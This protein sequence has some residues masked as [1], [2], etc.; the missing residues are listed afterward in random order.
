MSTP[1]LQKAEKLNTSVGPVAK[2]EPERIKVKT[3]D[4]VVS[5]GIVNP[6]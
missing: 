5:Y 6:F 2:P 3:D 1:A 4:K